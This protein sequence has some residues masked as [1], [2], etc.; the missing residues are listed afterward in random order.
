[1]L[2]ITHRLQAYFLNIRQMTSVYINALLQACLEVAVHA[3]PLV[4]NNSRNFVNNGLF[5][6]LNSHDTP[7]GTH[8][9]SGTPT[10]KNVVQ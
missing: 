9:L 10:G 5:E 8:G 6:F 7:S 1:M 2:F 3:P 4:L